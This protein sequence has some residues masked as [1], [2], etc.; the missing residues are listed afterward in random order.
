MKSSTQQTDEN[1]DGLGVIWGAARIGAA[2]GRG[3][4]QAF[5]LLASGQLA[6]ARKVGGRWAITR[7][8]LMRNFESPPT[9]EGGDVPAGT[10][11]FTASRKG[12]AKR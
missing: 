12:A 4:R 5:H 3:K 7:T 6:G 9:A 10:L 11:D 2:I 8:A 1:P